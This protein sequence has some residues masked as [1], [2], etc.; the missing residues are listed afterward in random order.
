M[1]DDAAH[2]GRG[3][4]APELER[5]PGI[6]VGCGCALVHRGG[7]HGRTRQQGGGARTAEVVRW[8]CSR[9]RSGE[10]EVLV[11]RRR[12]R[13]LTEEAV[14]HGSE[15]RVTCLSLTPSCC[16]RCLLIKM[17]VRN[18]RGGGI[19]VF[20]LGFRVGKLPPSRRGIL[21]SSLLFGIL[22]SAL[23]YFVLGV[24]IAFINQQK[25]S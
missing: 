14:G 15:A 8:R 1:A 25:Q 16:R 20:G 5:R 7:H 6:V 21:L 17:L 9:G 22:S 11:R 10:G 3:G 4:G 23:L 2:A 19:G 12:L 24:E 13:N 18:R